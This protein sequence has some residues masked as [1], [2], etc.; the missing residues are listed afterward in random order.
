MITGHRGPVTAIQLRGNHLVS[1]SSDG[2]IK[3]WDVSTGELIR[4]FRGHRSGLACIQYD[5]ERIVS[6]SSDKTIR[7]WDA[8][9]TINE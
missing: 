4:E 6:G 7:V 5:G 8:K 1:A 9:V 3:L 2:L